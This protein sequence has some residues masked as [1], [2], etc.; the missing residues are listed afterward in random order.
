MVAINFLPGHPLKRP[1]HNQTSECTMFFFEKV[2]YLV[3]EINT[4]GFMHAC[5]HFDQQFALPINTL[6]LLKHS[7]SQTN[8]ITDQTQIYIYVNCYCILISL[9]DP[10]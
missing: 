7:I 2:F 10:L 1:Y 6:T 5:S 3:L 8:Q 9:R 4:D